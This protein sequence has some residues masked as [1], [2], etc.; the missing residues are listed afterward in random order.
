MHPNIDIVVLREEITATTIYVDV[1][2]ETIT[3]KQ[4]LQVRQSE[5]G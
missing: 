3:R 1:Q 4:A 5:Y 2:E